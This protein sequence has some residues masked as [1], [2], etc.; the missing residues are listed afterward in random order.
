MGS[1]TPQN[2]QPSDSSN[3]DAPSAAAAKTSSSTVNTN[4]A[5]RLV[6]IT[7][8]LTALLVG[9]LYY[10]STYPLSTAK[11][12]LLNHKLEI[13]QEW[14]TFA[15]KIPFVKKSEIHF[16]T[17]RLERHKGDYR[18]MSKYLDLAQQAGYDPEMIARENI[19]AS[20]QSADLNKVRPQL[21]KLLEDPRGDVR[22][23][24]EA[25]VIGFL[26]FQLNDSALQLVRGWQQDFPSDARPHYLEGI[27]QKSIN[28][29]KESEQ[30]FLTALKVD[31]TYYAAAMD[32]AEVLLELKNTKRALAYLKLAQKDP[33]LLID[34]YVAQAHCYRMLGQTG[35]AEKIL[36]IVLRKIP[37]HNAAS[38]ELGRILV[39]DRRYAEAILL[40]QPIVD[41]DELL[42][43]PRQSLAMALRGVGRLEEAQVHFDTVEDIKYNLATA[44]QIVET[45]GSGPESIDDRLTV[46]ELFWNY[47][48][49]QDAMI[50]M[51]T[52]YQLN[53]KHLPTLEFMLKYYRVKVKTSPE[54][55]SQIV[56]F[57]REA[58]F[59]KAQANKSVN[60][61]TNTTDNGTATPHVPILPK[62]NQ[63]EN[64]TP[65]PSTN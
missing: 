60:D 3:N 50:W 5:T 36:R 62:Q 27:I 44:N 2:D 40:L 48:S 13:A 32:M 57:E 12:N 53:P 45:I 6:L 37:D 7:V 25:Y 65:E 24:C 11:A 31:P 51:R 52:A 26:Q 47:G 54:Q 59:A 28:N 23:I 33:L 56:Q 49:E 9:G 41:N 55:Q 63:P 42:T 14:I 34:S 38:N 10:A 15:Q 21:A 4:R 22:E 18:Q 17:A 1:E 35:R 16:L 46:A 58:A 8:I 20:A 61:G 64:T 30:C 19:L 29:F 39:V 43:D